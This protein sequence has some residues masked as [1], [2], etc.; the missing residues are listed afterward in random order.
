MQNT[1]IREEIFSIKDKYEN[2]TDDSVSEKIE[3]IKKLNRSIEERSSIFA[4]TFGI[5]G[6]IIFSLGIIIWLCFEKIPVSIV[7]SI[8]GFAIM[9]IVLPL[10]K[11]I[12]TVEKKKCVKKSS[13]FPTKF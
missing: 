13:T 5:F 3:M 6:A 8:L 11:V 7:I 2:I 4:L 1:P 10:R 12:L 9:A